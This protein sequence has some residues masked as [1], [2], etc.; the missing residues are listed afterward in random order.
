MTEPF[1]IDPALR[2][3][4]P[5]P[6]D[7]LLAWDGADAL[8]LE[9]AEGVAQAGAR[10][11]VLNDSFGALSCGLGHLDLTAYSDS[12][13]SGRATALN[14]AGRTTP[15]CD[16]A[17]LKGP[18]DLALLRV[19]KNL[20]HFEDELCHLSAHLAPGAPV[21]CGYMV[22]H[23][24]KASFDLLA[25][26]IG[27]TRTSLAARKARLIFASLERP[28]T[29]T[30]APLS[31][32][33]DGFD[34]PFVRGS[35]LFSREK[36]DI[37]T[38]FLLAHIPEGSFGNILDLGC[39]D[40]VLGIAA[41][42]RNP[43]ARLVFCDES[44]LAVDSAR[45]NYARHCGDDARFVWTH[46]YQDQAPASVDLVLCN[47]PFHQGHAIQEAVALQ[48]FADAHHVLVPGGRLRVVANAHLDYAG[49]LRRRFGGCR[50]VASNRKFAIYD[51]FRT[52]SGDRPA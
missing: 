16:L 14:T 26:I 8:L 34:A 32:R 47:P 25:R 9:H 4:P 15:L 50:L 17:D 18:Y 6:A 5:D 2:R 42:L 29:P 41:K 28:P 3:Y 46:C 27:E 24:A 38:R 10:V 13:I 39:G 12:Y 30:P 51:A 31:V 48:M 52:D 43:S 35:N 7:R 19:P 44:R 45:A 20:S 36:L 49:A 11:V 37:G 1:R 23:H 33:L 21:V 22:K 40:G